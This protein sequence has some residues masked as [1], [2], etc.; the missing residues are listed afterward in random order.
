MAGP[1]CLGY[2]YNLIDWMRMKCNFYF[3]IVQNKWFTC[4]VWILKAEVIYIIYIYEVIYIIYMVI[5]ATSMDFSNRS[6]LLEKTVFLSM[7]LN[8]GYIWNRRVFLSY[9]P[10]LC[11]PNGNQLFKCQYL[12]YYVI[13][14]SRFLR[15]KTWHKA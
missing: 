4:E 13:K 7:D 2:L 12:N 10:F 11:V 14:L 6:A 15:H 1:Q 3:E 5:C 9:S 8:N